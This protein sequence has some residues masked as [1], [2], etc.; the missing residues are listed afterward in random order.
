[1]NPTGLQ[2][3]AIYFSGQLT[4]PH[5]ACVSL[6]EEEWRVV[7]LQT[8]EE[9]A[10]HPLDPGAIS[11]RLARRV[12]RLVVFP[13]GGS[14]EIHDCDALNDFTADLST[15]RLGSFV[16]RLE[17]H[18]TIAAVATVLV[19]LSIVGLFKF[20][21]P[22]LA[23]Q[24]ATN[25]PDSVEQTLGEASLASFNA[26][27]IESGLD[28][29]A[30]T[31]LDRQL[32]RVLRP[33]EVAPRLHLRNLGNLPNAFALPGHLIVVTDALPGLLSDDEIA[34]VLAHEMGHLDARHAEQNL[35]LSSTALLL[36]ASATGDLTALTNFAA[37]LPLTLL[38]SGYSRDFERAADLMACERLTAAG[39]PVETLATALQRL[40]ESLPNQ[41]RQFSYLSTHPSSEERYESIHD[42]VPSAAAPTE[43]PD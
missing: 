14:L 39:I 25:L 35:L 23:R 26:F 43:T 15:Q 12:P 17:S 5:A 19:V 1:M 3:D 4:A 32:E 29:T 2:F 38:R 7:S 33:D 37:A 27:G 20:G 18:A 21:L 22:A 8:G 42:W 31:R 6:V 36:I 34:A 9:L 10:R 30:R 24:V 41:S 40:E 13:D 28:F 16:H 11:D